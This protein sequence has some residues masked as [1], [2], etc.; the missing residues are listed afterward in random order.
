M[1]NSVSA[2]GCFRGFWYVASRLDGHSAE[3]ALENIRQREWQTFRQAVSDRERILRQQQDIPPSWM[4][5]GPEKQ[6]FLLQDGE[7]VWQYDFTW[8]VG[9]PGY[10]YFAAHSTLHDPKEFEPGFADLLQRVQERAMRE[11]LPHGETW[12]GMGFGFSLQGR[13]Q[14]ILEKEHGINWRGPR[15]DQIHNAD[16]IID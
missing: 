7:T 1:T 15:L 16:V 14:E 6:T 10:D 2:A 4:K 9:W 3:Y 12:G 13:M 5:E 8:V 11:L